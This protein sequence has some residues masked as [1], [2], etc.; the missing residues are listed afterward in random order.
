MKYE[1]GAK[2]PHKK[3]S[4]ASKVTEITCEKCGT[5]HVIQDDCHQVQRYIVA[6]TGGIITDPTI[7]KCFECV[8]CG[9][10]MFVKG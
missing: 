7:V 10:V 1:R 5:M 9:Y 4:A 3:G 2:M 8:K 6:S